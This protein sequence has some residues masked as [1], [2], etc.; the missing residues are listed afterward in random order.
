MPV[1]QEGLKQLDP[2][3]SYNL[4]ILTFPDI[5]L[6]APAIKVLKIILHYLTLCL[7]PQ[8]IEIKSSHQLK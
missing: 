1:K 8:S 3:T 2:S 4:Y 5:E 7:W 6:C